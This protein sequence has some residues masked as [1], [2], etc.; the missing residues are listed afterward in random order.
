MTETT[1]L[2]GNDSTPYY[3]ASNYGPK[4]LNSDLGQVITP[5]ASLAESG[6]NFT[7]STIV[8]RQK[9]S[10]QTIAAQAFTEPQA[11]QVLEGELTL[12]MAGE[13]NRLTTGDVA[14]IPGNTTFSYWSEVLYTKL[15]AAAIGGGLTDSLINESNEWD[16]AVFPSY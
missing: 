4:Y 2:P 16:Y 10:N 11:L 12:T 8:M 7:I 15:Y 3:I 14:F 6:G 5:R 9:Q 1:P 13:T